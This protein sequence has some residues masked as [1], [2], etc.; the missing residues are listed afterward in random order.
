MSPKPI[1]L[2]IAV[3]ILVVVTVWPPV[4]MALARSLGF[5]PSRLGGW[6]M[7]AAP[8]ESF[9]G[10]EIFVLTPGAELPEGVLGTE[11]PHRPDGVRFP[12]EV[13]LTLVTPAEMVALDGSGL[14]EGQL[15]TLWSHVQR[16]QAFPGRRS[17]SRLAGYLR[18]LPLAPQGTRAVLIVL[19][20]P[21]VDLRAGH[22]VVAVQ[23]FRVVGGEADAMTETVAG[24]EALERLDERIA[25]WVAEGAH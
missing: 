6:G 17:A 20:A 1:R 16:M 2:A 8:D 4:H 7:Y 9:T 18:T 3:A 21:G 19:T 25:R 13:H 5:A 14:E 11:S 22:T 15:E 24:A 10:V 12:F 23:A